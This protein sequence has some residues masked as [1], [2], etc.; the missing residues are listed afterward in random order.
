MPR[1]NQ[2]LLVGGGGHC[3][4]VVN[5]LRRIGEKVAGIVD[6]PENLG[7]EVMGAKVVGTDDDLPRLARR[8]FKTLITLGSVG[9]NNMDRLSLFTRAEVAGMV[10]GKL[11]SP[12]AIVAE[13]SAIGDGTVVMDGAI[14][15]RGTQIGRNCIINTG[16][17]IEHDC[18][19]GDH[20]HIASG[21]VCSGEVEVGDGAFVGAG[22]TVIQGRKVG[23]GAVVGAGTTVIQDVTGSAIAVGSPA[24]QRSDSQKSRL[25]QQMLAPPNISIKEAWK[26]INQNQK[27]TLFI[28][29]RGDI[30]V[31]SVADGDIR[32]WILA[33]K[34]ITENVRGIM[35][36]KPVTARKNDDKKTMRELLLRNKIECLPVV[37]SAGRVVDVEDLESCLG[38]KDGTARSNSLANVP[39]VIMA[40]GKGSRLHPFTKVLPKP[41]VPIGDKPII[42][43]IID[44]FRE[45]GASKFLVSINY[46]ASMIRAYFQDA[47]MPLDLSF[48]QEA[49]P[50]GTAGSLHLIR[51]KI[52]RT[53]I[54]SN[55]DILVDTDYDDLLRFHRAK[56]NAV[57]MVCSMKHSRLPYGVVQIRSGGGL[58]A[59][60]EKPELDNLVNTGLYVM[61]PSMFKFVKKDEFMDATTLISVAKSKRCRIGVYPIPE[62]AWSDIGQL[63]EYQAA[64]RKF[65]NLSGAE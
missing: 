53:F 11:I 3:K 33:D 61:E 37:D 38:P 64:M 40:G 25:I 58:K 21:A 48:F 49:K 23:D 2:F 45:F 59:I 13:D 30:L 44:R 52:R 36:P 20:V 55:C 60:K 43:I 42:E 47:D 34:N 9:R 46:R 4:S 51:K 57:T 8:K 14:V 19:I 5:I 29:D 32:R 16:S 18:R 31:G 62:K 56:R 12:K 7:K 28:V 41:L 26:R 15:N 6:L 39:I 35:R 10:F 17:V 24:R 27:R 22:A 50:L 63:E 54:M 1:G 65:E